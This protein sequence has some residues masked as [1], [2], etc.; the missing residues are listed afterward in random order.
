M[1]VYRDVNQVEGFCKEDPQ[2]E[3]TEIRKDGE[4]APILLLHSLTFVC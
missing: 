1:N 2:T 4:T 3:A